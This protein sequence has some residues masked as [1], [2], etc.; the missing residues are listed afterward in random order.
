MNIWFFVLLILAVALVIGPVS[1]LRPKPAQRH[2]EMLRMTAAGQGV[3]FGLRTLPKLK[4]AAEDPSP[5]PVYYL[6]PTVKMQSL[7]TWT[8][9][10]TDYEHEGNFY[11]EWDFEGEYRPGAT[12]CGFLKDILP[13]MPASVAAISQGKAGTC[14]F[15]NEKG[16]LET[17]DALVTMLKDLHNAVVTE[18]TAQHPG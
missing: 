16:D 14:V 4:T 10:R 2:K 6:S 12:I 7:P 3:R 1:M 18:I 15:W 17:L 8:L 5:T 11:Q 13:T 9:M